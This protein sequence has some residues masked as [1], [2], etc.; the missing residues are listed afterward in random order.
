MPV[1][2][3][4]RAAAK[5]SPHVEVGFSPTIALISLVRTFVSDFYARVLSANVCEMVAMATHELLENAVKYGIDDQATLRVDVEH[6]DASDRVSIRIRNRST[7]ANIESLRGVLTRIKEQPDPL[8]H[9]VTL[10]RE[11][12][13][14]EHGSGLGLARIRAEGDMDL[15]LEVTGDLVSIL[16]QCDVEK[17]GEE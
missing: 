6:E 4:P 7:P 5:R 17:R 10:M 14:R 11:T 2:V 13:K 16:A 1:P 3:N 12:S 8:A 9:Y 15:T